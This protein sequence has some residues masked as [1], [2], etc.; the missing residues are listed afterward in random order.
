MN[1]ERL[2]RKR[3]VL[4]KGHFLLSSGLH[5]DFYFEKFRILEDPDATRKLSKFI[6]QE[7]KDKGVEWVVGP[8]TGGVIIAYEVARN[9]KCKCG[10]AEVKE[11]KR[12]VGRDFEIAGKKVLIA[13]DVLTTGGS[14]IGTIEAIKEKKAISS[15][16]P[17]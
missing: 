14:I 2:L 4:K 1:I 5:S 9:L 16:S 15:V 11:G 7:Y 6:I 17:F 8:L 12:F 13:D 3:G 10:V